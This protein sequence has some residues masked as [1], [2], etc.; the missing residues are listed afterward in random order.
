MPVT[1]ETRAGADRASIEDGAIE[2]RNLTVEFASPDELPHLSGSLAP[3]AISGRRRVL[4]GISFS[5]RP[6]TTVGIVGPTGAGKTTLLRALLRLIE[7]DPKTVLIDGHDITEIPLADLR[8]AVGMAPQDA[9][10]FGDTVANNVRFAVPDAE[11]ARVLAAVE[12]SQLNAD[13]DQL[14]DGLET[15]LGERG[16]NL[17]G[18]QRQRTSLARVVLQQP[19]VLLLDDTLSAIDTHTSDAILAGL[20]PVMEGRTTIVVAHR[21]SAVEHA[22]QILVL[23]D[24]RIT[25]RGTHAE[26]IALGG[27]YAAIHQRQTARRGFAEQLGLEDPS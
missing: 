9:F 26:L 11:L 16:V 12:I 25:E 6:G 2:V 1:I 15:I 24:G 13:L 21:L 8:R 18:G 10:L 5:V 22:D 7:I 19:R 23:E 27:Y 14:P 20:R 4:D 17:S 3:E